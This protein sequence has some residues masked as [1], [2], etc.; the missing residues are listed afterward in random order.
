MVTPTKA[1]DPYPYPYPLPNPCYMYV[2]GP[3]HHLICICFDIP[4]AH[5]MI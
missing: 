3:Y 4:A 1:T 5:I 2:C